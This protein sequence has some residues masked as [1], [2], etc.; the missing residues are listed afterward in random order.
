MARMVKDF[1]HSMGL[2]TGT[3]INDLPN[4]HGI[5][6]KFGHVYEGI[7]WNGTPKRAFKVYLSN[8]NI[9][10]GQLS[11]FLPN[12]P[13]QISK[14]NGTCHSNYQD[15]NLSCS[16]EIYTSNWIRGHSNKLI[17]IN[18]ANGDSYLGQVNHSINW[19][20]L[21]LIVPDGYGKWINRNR[22]VYIGNWKHGAKNGLGRITY[23][24][25]VIYDGQWV[26]GK[27]NGIGST[28]IQDHL[29]IETQSTYIVIYPDGAKVNMN[30]KQAGQLFKELAW[31][32]LL[33]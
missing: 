25:N 23:P 5:L 26:N 1:N 16:Q 10:I 22:T 7:W 19:L 27:P 2:Y 13:G 15:H 12:G 14:Y 30:A 28:S 24:S 32:N 21:R 3:L 20:D 18:Y 4:G 8:N 29:I 11:D 9:Y 6:I 17:K 33:V 31:V